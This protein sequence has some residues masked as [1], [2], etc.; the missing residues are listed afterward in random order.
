ML[1]DVPVEPDGSACF[2][3][4]AGMPIYFMALDAE[5]RAVQ[6]MRSFTHL[7]PGEVQG[8]VGCHEHRGCRPR[9]RGTW[10]ALRHGSRRTLQPPE[11]G[12]A[13]FDYS[14]I[15]QPVL[16]QHCVECHNS[17]DAAEAARPDRRQDRLL[18]RLVRRAGPGEAGR[19]RQPVR[20]LDSRPTTARS[21]TSWRSTPKT[22]GSPQSKL[23]EVVLSGH[24]DE[25]GKPRSTM[26]DAERRRILA[27][28]DLNVPYYGTSETA[29]PDAPGCRQMYPAA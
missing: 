18:Q 17:I 11:W 7:M 3:V 9:R 14:R 13:G 21:G 2:R 23:A 22:W 24:P 10:P 6:R 29:Y 25:D 16:D 12:A 19:P 5:G 4:P 20:Q 27:W 1:G 28:I 15:V 8:C 26:D